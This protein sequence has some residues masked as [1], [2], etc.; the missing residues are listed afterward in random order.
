MPSLSKH[1]FAKCMFPLTQVLNRPDKSASELKSWRLRS[2]MYGRVGSTLI[3]CAFGQLAV[4]PR[5]LGS[6][7]ALLPPTRAKS[8]GSSLLFPSPPSPAHIDLISSSLS[9]SL[10]NPTP[11]TVMNL[12]LMPW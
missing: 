1:V 12:Q 7:G 2:L 9:S 10:M 3:Q 8:L 5:T 6:Q 4:R 11:S